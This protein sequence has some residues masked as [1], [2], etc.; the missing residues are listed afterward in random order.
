V[1]LIRIRRSEYKGANAKAVVC[2]WIRLRFGDG[3]RALR[4]GVR[5][6]I[7]CRLSGS[8][9]RQKRHLRLGKVGEKNVPVFLNVL[10]CP[11]HLWVIW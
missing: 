11:A 5:F 2:E 10:D 8:E 6:W 1:L 4:Q 9:R 3:L 7:S